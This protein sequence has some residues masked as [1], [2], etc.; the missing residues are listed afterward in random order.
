MLR[1]ELRPPHP[2]SRMP[3]L[4]IAAGLVAIGS[5]RLTEASCYMN[6]FR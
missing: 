3:H 6:S 1:R 4:R 5:G 2:D